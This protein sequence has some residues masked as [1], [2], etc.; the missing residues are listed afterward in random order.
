MVKR[1][2]ILFLFLSLFLILF[3]LSACSNKTSVSNDN[4][5]KEVLFAS[6][7]GL[8]GLQCCLNEE[9]L[10]LYE[11]ECCTDPNDSSSTYCS[12]KCNFGEPNTF[13]RDT[14]P[15]CDEGSVCYEGYCQLAGDNSQP[16]FSDGTCREG[17]VCGDGVC[18][19]CGLTG[20]PCCD[21]NEYKC[22]NENVFDNSR[23]DCINDVCVECGYA[24]K[25]VCQNQPFCNPGHLQNNT[26]CLLCGGSNQPCCKSQEE[27]ILFCNDGD[28]LTCES[29]FCL[30]K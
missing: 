2:N 7:C 24:S 15:K 11:Q 9:T 27:N 1:I 18:V 12:D 29:G 23:T 21:N 25:S 5:K 14:E 3:I 20:N 26:S 4:W 8:D 10:C 6:E 30:K 16:C 19:E 17:S 28:N 13:C 22:K